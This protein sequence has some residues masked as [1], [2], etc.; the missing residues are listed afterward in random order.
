MKT[1]VIFAGVTAMIVGLSITTSAQA[2]VVVGPLPTGTMCPT[3]SMAETKGRAVYCSFYDQNVIE[4]GI[5]P[6]ASNVPANMKMQ[7]TV[8]R[9]TWCVISKP[10]QAPT[11]STTSPTAAPKE[12]VATPSKAG[13]VAE[14][15]ASGALVTASLCGTGEKVVFACN[16]GKKS[17]SVCS[18]QKGLQ[19]RYGVDRNSLDISLDANG[20]AAGQYPLAGGGVWYMRFSNGS[21]NYVV[22]TAESSSVDKAGV[23]V[24]QGGKRSAAL[25]CK[26]AATVNEKLAGEPKDQKGFDV[27]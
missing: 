13:R 26:N 8:G 19:Y 2:G 22:Y 27:P 1:S 6:C 3:G 16:T 20:A 18:T 15:G 12:E 21:T 25:S 7:S 9:N 24:E 17:V 4:A 5:G 23:V 14:A 11:K 10:Q